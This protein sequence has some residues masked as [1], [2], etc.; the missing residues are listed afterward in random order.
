M[1]NSTAQ[2]ILNGHLTI[3]DTDTEFTRCDLTGM[4]ADCWA[5]LVVDENGNEYDVDVNQH[6][7]ADIVNAEYKRQ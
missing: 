2:L 6:D 5:C 3:K 1:K 7:A 4:M